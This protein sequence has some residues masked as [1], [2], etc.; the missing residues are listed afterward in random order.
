MNEYTIYD[1]E[2]QELTAFCS[3]CGHMETIPC[4]D[5]Q[6]GAYTGRKKVIQSIFPDVSPDIREM[7][8]S[9]WCGPCFALNL[10]H[11]PQKTL[12]ELTEYTVSIFPADFLNE[13]FSFRDNDDIRD[14][15][16]EM[17]WYDGTYNDEPDF[18]EQLG[19]VRT[20]ITELADRI[21]RGEFE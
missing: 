3:V 14:F 20:K 6:M 19:K 11:F 8:I 4:T 1:N 12:D 17:E 13:G 5:E 15:I 10:M 16:T 21:D 7:L 18:R 2:K 9:G